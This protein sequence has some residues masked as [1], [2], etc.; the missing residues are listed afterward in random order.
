MRT[1]TLLT[2]L[3]M[4]FLNPLRPSSSFRPFSTRRPIK[5]TVIDHNDP[6]PIK[7][8]EGII[9]H[10]EGTLT[11]Y[12]PV[13]TNTLPHSPTLFTYT[14]S[15]LIHKQTLHFP[16]SSLP[17]ESQKIT[18]PFHPSHIPLNLMTLLQNSSIEIEGACGGELSCSTCHILLQENVYDSLGDVEEEEG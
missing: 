2:R 16:P 9:A 5:F 18:D 4:R 3:P 10:K 14:H 11:F 17:D 7:Q 12:S 13:H 15:S 1:L 8:V 6:D